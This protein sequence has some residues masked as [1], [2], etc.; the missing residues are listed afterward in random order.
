ML[1]PDLLEEGFLLFNSGKFYDAHEV[2]EDLWRA[3]MEP[4]LKTC[5][6]GLIQAAVG[7][8]HLSR[9]NPVGARSQLQ[10]S[11]RNLRTAGLKPG[12]LDVPGL[13][14]QLETLLDDLPDSVP[15]GVAIG[16]LK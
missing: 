12:D 8:H 6:Q 7:L 13:I 9:R 14:E 2:W 11:V 10:K 15:S 16:R 3:T 5:F 4:G 1:V